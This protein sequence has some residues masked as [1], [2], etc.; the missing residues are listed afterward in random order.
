MA[1]YKNTLQRGSV[2]ILVFREAGVWYA[3][4]LEFNIVET[5]DTS[6]EAMLLL[7]E[8]VQGYLESA[9]KT[10]ARPHILNQAVDREYEEKWRGSIQAKRQPN[11]VFF[12]GRMNILGGRALVPA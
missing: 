1:K 4:A 3:V 7:F 11:S 9:K 6:R 8:A 2:R 5:G 12:A 10:K